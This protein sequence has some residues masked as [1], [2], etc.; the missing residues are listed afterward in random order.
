MPNEK[1]TLFLKKLIQEV[2]NSYY[3]SRITPLSIILVG[4]KCE[5]DSLN[6]LYNTNSDLDVIIVIKNGDPF[7]LKET[8]AGIHLDISIIKNDDLIN[9][10]Y[11]ALNGSPFVGKIFS[12]LSNYTII[13]DS[14]NIGNFFIRT[15][16]LLYKLFTSTN[17]P[18]FNFISTSLKNISSNIFD[19]DKNEN[20]TKLYCTYNR[21][22]EHFFEYI[23]KLLYPFHTS[24]S[25][26][27]EIF[28]NLFEEINGCIDHIDKNKIT[29]NL[30][31][32]RSCTNRVCPVFCSPY[33]GIQLTSYFK[34]EISSG[35]ITS[36]FL[37]YDNLVSENSILFVIEEELNKSYL[38]KYQ[39]VGVK[40]IIPF[41]SAH[42]LNQYY[43]LLSQFSKN[44]IHASSDKRMNILFSV[45]NEFNKNRFE[46][47]LNHSLKAIF[48]LKI[49]SEISQEKKKIK[50]PDLYNW[51]V[52]LNFSF[53]AD[54]SKSTI[55][56]EI[57]STLNK[58][59][60]SINERDSMKEKEV[61]VVY[62]F[63][64]IVKALRLEIRNLNFE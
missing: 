43:Q 54:K 64:G 25:Y 1:N 51:L 27:G 48:V 19:L 24:G 62:L 53:P 30:A 57:L 3:N 46:P 61:M 33:I 41:F 36:Y 13:Q 5:F 2:T 63:W 6:S 55:P 32:L 17:L 52:A 47:I 21:L 44:Y 42:Q 14:D 34:D 38:N 11:S 45:I 37:G 8:Y 60:I 20:A 50:T 59:L 39:A 18:N 23:S 16:Q 9:L 29:L 28:N 22:S 40:T 15:T 31:F 26:R 4:S 56:F 58:L 12:S 7:Q 35:N 10:F 49:L